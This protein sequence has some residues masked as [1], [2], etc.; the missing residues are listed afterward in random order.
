M[1][2]TDAFGTYGVHIKVQ[3]LQDIINF[4]VCAR[5]PLRLE[6]RGGMCRKPA[7]G[8]GKLLNYTL[9]FAPRRRKL[10]N[11]TFAPRPHASSFVRACVASPPHDGQVSSLDKLANV[12]Q[13][14]VSRHES[15]V[16]SWSY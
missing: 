4:A 11:C 15:L 14:I 7:I 13:A 16:A 10:L 3:I 12:D 1:L 5:T 9:L 6:L 8:K 2:Q